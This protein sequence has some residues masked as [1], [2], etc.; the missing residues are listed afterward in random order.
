MKRLSWITV[1]NPR[2]LVSIATDSCVNG[3]DGSSYF[4][5]SC[6]FRYDP[7]HKII[8]HDVNVGFHA[9][10]SL[11]YE[12]QH[13]C[14]QPRLVALHPVCCSHHHPDYYCMDYI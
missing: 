13:T 9:L 12:R 2:I 8:L 6:L 1:S 10:E 5:R 4:C 3:Y 11:R 14:V 7:L